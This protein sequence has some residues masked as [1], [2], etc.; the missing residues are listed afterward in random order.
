MEAAKH[1]VP[2]QTRKG[3]YGEIPRLYYHASTTDEELEDCT[4]CRASCL[5]ESIEG[6][7][8]HL[9]SIISVWYRL[10]HYTMYSNARYKVF[11]SYL[12]SS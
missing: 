5:D 10:Y 12:A 7:D 2:E 4:S 8:L 3:G 1:V 9:N 11:R 6:V